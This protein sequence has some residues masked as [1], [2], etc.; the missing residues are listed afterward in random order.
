MRRPI[1]M[2][3]VGLFCFCY[4]AIGQ[5]DFTQN[6][7]SY[8]NLNPSA[9]GLYGTNLQIQGRLDNN[10]EIEKSV[11]ISKAQFETFIDSISSGIGGYIIYE[12]FNAPVV[13]GNLFFDDIYSGYSLISYSGSSTQGN[14][15]YT[16]RKPFRNKGNLNIGIGGN[17]D[18]M[19]NELEVILNDTGTTYTSISNGS[20]TTIKED[21]IT[22][23]TDFGVVWNYKGLNIGVSVLAWNNYFKKDDLRL[24]HL[25]NYVGFTQYDWIVS[26]SVKITPG[27]VSVYTRGIYDSLSKRY[28]DCQLVQTSLMGELSELFITGIQWRSKY[29]RNILDRSLSLM[30]GGVITKRFK[31]VLSC[32]LLL[33]TK[34]LKTGELDIE[35]N[36]V[37]PEI[38]LSYRFK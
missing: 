28:N 12:S 21:K 25:T 23:A 14:L 2:L 20:Y 4:E 32:D 10:R 37:I 35:K 33:R 1:Q 16:Y 36:R 24:T 15:S 27:L 30:L 17:L 8:M 26:K 5:S 22:L 19:T 18:Y 34:N 7:N 6:Y 9:V 3:I 11:V 31:A 29:F 38:L 13:S